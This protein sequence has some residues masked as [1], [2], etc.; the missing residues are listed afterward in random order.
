M[1]WRDV[2]TD[3]KRGQSATA[4]SAAIMEGEDEPLFFSM[5]HGAENYDRTRFA[6]GTFSFS[7]LPFHNL[8]LRFLRRSLSVDTPFFLSSEKHTYHSFIDWDFG[9]EERN[10]AGW[11][12]DDESGGEHAT[13]F[14]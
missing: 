12:L 8:F 1:T 9:A 3:Y 5:E 14:G 11:I 2:V 13:I 6:P 7:L 10:H 4:T